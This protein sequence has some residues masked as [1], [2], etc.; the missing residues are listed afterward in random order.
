MSD[1]AL[2]DLVRGEP[3]IVVEAAESIIASR[4]NS[5]GPTV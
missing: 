2:R 4:R 1:E 3:E 5:A